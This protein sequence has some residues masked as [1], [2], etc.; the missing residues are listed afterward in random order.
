MQVRRPCHRRPLR[1]GRDRREGGRN[2]EDTGGRDAA[3]K[4]VEPEVPEY[5]LFAG[6]GKMEIN[7][8]NRMMEFVF[9]L[10]SKKIVWTLAAIVL[11][12]TA[13]SL[14]GQYSTYVLV[15]GH[16]N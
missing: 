1:A 15:D 2:A 16:M 14:I 5:S 8:E 3:E 9:R 10:N 13:A 12:L 11:L 7:G 4:R 6:M